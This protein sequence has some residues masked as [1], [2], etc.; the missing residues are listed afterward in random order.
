MLT[1]MRRRAALGLAAAATAALVSG[2]GAAPATAADFYVH[3]FQFTLSPANTKALSD[4]GVVV[5]PLRPATSRVDGSGDS[6][7]VTLTFPVSGPS[8]SSPFAV[9]GGVWFLNTRTWRGVTVTRQ[10]FVFEYPLGGLVGAISGSGGA[11]RMWVGGSAMYPLEARLSD[12]F[13]Q[14]LNRVAGAD[15]V[16]QAPFAGTFRQCTNG[17]CP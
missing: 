10:Q 8:T 15:V 17:P 5:I 2:A 16:V 9:D 1:R 3:S 4:R 12:S 13:V 14:A 6:R 7:T 11:R